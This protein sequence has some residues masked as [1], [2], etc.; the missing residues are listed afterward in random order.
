MRHIDGKKVAERR[1]GA[2]LTYRGLAAASGVSA[3]YLAKLEQSNA[4]RSPSAEVI[5]K[6]A[7]GLRLDVEDIT[8]P[9][10]CPCCSNALAEAS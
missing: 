7:K 4:T 9:C 3:G 5:A 10:L 2:G 1:L 8:F 6:I